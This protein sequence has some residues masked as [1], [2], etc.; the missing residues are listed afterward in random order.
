MDIIVTGAT[1]MV[2]SELIRQAIAD[3]E[4]NSILAISRSPVEITSPKLSVVLQSSFLHYDTLAAEFAKA[5]ACIWCL[6]ISQAQVNREAYQQITYDYTIAAATAMLTA[7][8]AI[9]FVFL[10]GA[11]ADSSEKS[12]TLF[13]R[14]KGK[15]EN[16]LRAM[17][18]THLYIARP[19][20]INPLHPNKK[21]PFVYKL[22]LPLLPLLKAIAPGLVIDSDDLARALLHLAKQGASQTILE[23]RDL[24]K[25][26]ALLNQKKSST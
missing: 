3:P 18:F 5:T 11:G 26:A 4:I 17:A 7:N 6:G 9:R 2:G 22:F 25:I 13:A 24:K 12:K 15:T 19:A 1:G 10:S 23:N 14:V 16:A 21:A 20:G 8:P